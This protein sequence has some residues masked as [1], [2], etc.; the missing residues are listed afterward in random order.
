MSFW[1]SV[2]ERLYEGMEA[3]TPQQWVGSHR[4][5]FDEDFA[6]NPARNCLNVV[7]NRTN[8]AG[9]HLGQLMLWR[10]HRG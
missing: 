3:L 9:Y 6:K 10:A 5:I 2:N 8:H 1:E 4:A 7:L